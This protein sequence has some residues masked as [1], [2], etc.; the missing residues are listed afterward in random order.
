MSDSEDLESASLSTQVILAGV[1]ELA[2]RD[3]T[4]AHA[5]E[6]RR[7]CNAAMDA[8]EGDVLG[9]VTEAEVARTLNELEAAGLVDG[10]RDA[11]SP[12]GKGRPTYRL[13]ADVGSVRARLADDERAAPLADRID[14][15]DQ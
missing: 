2:T 6:I 14:S 3:E 5:G 15:I 11:T 9:T 12:T 10:T 1:T 4:P 7:T 13:A 8:V